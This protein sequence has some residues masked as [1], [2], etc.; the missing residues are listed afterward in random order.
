MES[1]VLNQLYL[2]QIATNERS[3]C[4]RNKHQQQSK[5]TNPN[6]F[7]VNGTISEQFSQYYNIGSVDAGVQKS[8]FHSQDDG[9]SIE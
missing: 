6:D 5:G 8:H 4:E 7:Y 1:I 9:A 2:Q 3:S